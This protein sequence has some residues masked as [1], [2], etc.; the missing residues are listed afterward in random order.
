[1]SLVCLMKRVEQVPKLKLEFKS[2]MIIKLI[3]I[4]DRS[5]QLRRQLRGQGLNNRFFYTVPFI[6]ATWFPD[7]T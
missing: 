2:S 1:M 3:S 6:S 4:I 7:A 5:G